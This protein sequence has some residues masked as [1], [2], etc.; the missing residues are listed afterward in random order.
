MTKKELEQFIPTF[1]EGALNIKQFYLLS[2]I[3]KDEYIKELLQLP[4]EVLGEVDK[5]ILKFYSIELRPANNFISM[6]E[7]LY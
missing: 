7:S 6:E 4:K 2:R 3:E 1:R 5:H